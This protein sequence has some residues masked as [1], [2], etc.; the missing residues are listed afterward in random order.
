MYGASSHNYEYL[1]RYGRVTKKDWTRS[2]SIKDRVSHDYDYNG[3]RTSRDINATTA[4]DQG[5][6]YDDLNRLISMDQG[7][8]TGSA[9]SSKNFEEDWTLEALGNWE[10][11]QHDDDGNG[12]YSAAETED[13]DHNEANEIASIDSSST[14][15]AH[16]AA[17]NMTKTPT[18]AGYTLKWDAWNRLAQISNGSTT[19]TYSYDGLGRRI[20]T[21]GTGLTDN[22]FFY[23][24]SFQV[25]E[26]RETSESGAT[27][28]N[29]VWHPYYVDAL[30]VRYEDRDATSGYAGTDEVQ[31]V[32]HDANF[33]VIAIVNGSASV[34]ERYTYNPYGV[35]TKRSS[36]FGTTGLV[37]IDCPYLFTGRRY[38]DHSGIYYYRARFYDPGL[39]RFLGRD[40]IEYGFL[41]NLYCFVGDNPC[42]DVDP[43]GMIVIPPQLVAGVGGCG[44]GFTMSFVGALVVNSL[45]DTDN[46]FC[47]AVCSGVTGCITDAAIAAAAV[48]SPTFVPYAG[49][50]GGVIGSGVGEACLHVFCGKNH[51]DACT[52]FNALTSGALGCLGG[53]AHD[54]ESTRVSLGV[55][56][57]VLGLDVG[58]LSAACDPLLRIGED[59]DACCTFST[60]FGGVWSETVECNF[61][62]NAAACCARAADGY[63]WDYDVWFARLGACQ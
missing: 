17:G 35:F 18:L 33:N 58:V 27:V 38:D 48:T 14:N 28:E 56:L 15:I 20:E 19:Y 50:I 13:R 46:G 11:F 21:S 39:G 41:K 26:V 34:R 24:T 55:L 60:T 16:D 7:N 52:W 63:L 10:Q 62:E 3:N 42:R 36:S 53:F 6:G 47:C 45:T 31:Y 25:V 57:G 12:S 51:M 2:G 5:Y 9:I 23:N 37:D 4:H 44:L 29:Y 43:S 22:H 1:D 61:G 59:I 32:L 49:C 54:A 30:A 8:W 40:P